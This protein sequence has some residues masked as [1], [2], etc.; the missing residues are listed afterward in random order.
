MYILWTG[1]INFVIIK[2][3]YSGNNTFKGK[4]EIVGA[5]EN[6]PAVSGSF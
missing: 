1:V 6:A 5:V 3:P 2:L 4:G